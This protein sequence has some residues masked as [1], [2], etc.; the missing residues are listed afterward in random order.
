MVDPKHIE[1][2]TTDVNGFLIGGMKAA[3]EQ[4][5]ANAEK[6]SKPTQEFKSPYGEVVKKKPKVNK[7][8]KPQGGRELVSFVMN[9]DMKKIRHAESVILS[10]EARFGV[11][12]R[13]PNG[14]LV[15]VVQVCFTWNCYLYALYNLLSIGINT[16]SRT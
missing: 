2:S 6:E 16:Q 9:E 12:S 15:P 1:E 14:R 7:S 4:A 5:V 8:K 10:T 11:F 3:S 13:D